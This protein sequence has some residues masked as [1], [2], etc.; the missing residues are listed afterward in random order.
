MR[1]ALLIAALALVTARAP[2]AQ[3]ASPAITGKVV[4]V[5]NGA[6]VA[7]PPEGVFV[8][9]VD[10][11][12]RK[13]PA[14]Q[15]LPERE[16]VQRNTQFEP[17]VLVVP[18]GTVVNFPNKD[19]GV[20][21]NVFSP[22]P[23]FDLGKYGYGKAETH[24]FGCCGQPLDRDIEIYCDIH[25]CMWARVK[26]VD[27]LGPEYI[28]HTDASGAY[29]LSGIPAGKYE[30]W[31]WTVGSKPVHADIELAGKSVSVTEMHIQQEPFNP[32]KHKNKTNQNYTNTYTTGRCT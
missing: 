3:P 27:V 24:K 30:V 17:H 23:F 11:N 32:L 2:L 10:K 31:A 16:I 26:V 25:K 14:D 19:Q 20:D 7:I 12:G 4:V 18:K 13:P 22:D 29:S 1:T 8:W 28:T 15:K 6:A 5:A 9:L 21:H